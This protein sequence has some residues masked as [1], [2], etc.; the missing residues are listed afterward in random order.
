MSPRPTTRGLPLAVP[1]PVAAIGLVSELAIPA[2]VAPPSAPAVGIPPFPQKRA[3]PAATRT[4]V[5]AMPV[6]PAPIVVVPVG[7][8]PP[9]RNLTTP[10]PARKSAAARTLA[11][12]AMSSEV[13]AGM[14]ATVGRLDA[15]GMTVG[16][17]GAP[18]A[19]NVASRTARARRV[20]RD[21]RLAETTRAPRHAEDRAE[22]EPSPRV[23]VLAL[24]AHALAFVATPAPTVRPVAAVPQAATTQRAR[25]SACKRSSRVPA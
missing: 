15:I 25:A 6:D 7:P 22:R 14:P 18:D 17:K 19:T 2:G 23:P 5:A 4:V 12:S 3:A 24:V 21:L 10:G 1:G 13:L 11:V 16:L 8:P 9:R 20:G